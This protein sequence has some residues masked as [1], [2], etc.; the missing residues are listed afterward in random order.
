M[1]KSTCYVVVRGYELDSF[2]HLNNSVYLNYAEQ[3]KWEFLHEHK[4]LEIVEH[5]GLFPVILENNIRYMH[6]LRLLDKVRIESEWKSTE[7][8]LHFKHTFYNDATGKKS[9]R[10]TGKL[11]FADKNRM[12]SDIPEEIYR[13]MQDQEE[14]A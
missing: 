5:Y 2:G 11:M 3:A 14:K 9:C 7:K 6:E 10:I 13:F 1:M 12:V 4:L 8:I